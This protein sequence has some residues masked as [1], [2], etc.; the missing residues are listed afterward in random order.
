LGTTSTFPVLR[1]ADSGCGFV[2]TATA[3]SIL[4]VVKTYV[5]ASSGSNDELALVDMG[6]GG[7]YTEY[8]T[9]CRVQDGELALANFKGK[10]SIVGPYVLSEGASV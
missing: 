5:A 4:F 1:D 10:D 3:P 2:R 9:I 6:A 7:A 8:Y